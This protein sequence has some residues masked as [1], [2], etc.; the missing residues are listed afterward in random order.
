MRRGLVL[1]VASSSQSKPESVLE[2]DYTMLALG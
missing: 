1:E 2:V